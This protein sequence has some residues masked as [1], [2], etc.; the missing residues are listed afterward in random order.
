VRFE[1]DFEWRDLGRWVTADADSKDFP[2]VLQQLTSSGYPDGRHTVEFGT[3]N[4]ALD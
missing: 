3:S 2:K 1:L 4:H